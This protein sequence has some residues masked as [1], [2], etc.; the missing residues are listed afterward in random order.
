[1]RGLILTSSIVL[2]LS[3][4]SSFAGA[5][6]RVIQV[7][8]AAE[9]VPPG[10]ETYR[11]YIYDM[12][13]YVDRKDK[14]EIV[15]LLKKQ[16]DIVEDSGLSPK[17]MQFFHTVPIIAS[18]MGCTD[19]GPPIACYSSIRQE[20][21]ARDHTFTVWD[22]KTMSWSNPNFV[23]LAADAGT[24]VIRFR[25]I[26]LKHAEDPVMLH[27]LLHAYHHKLMGSGFDNLGIKAMY[28]KAVSTNAFP[29]D[30]YVMT[31]AHEFF[32]VTASVF[33][34]GKGALSEPKTRAALK[35]KMPK[36]YKFLVE[37]FGF[38]PEPSATPVAETA[39]PVE[40]AATAPANGT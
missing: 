20:T 23:D 10:F 33:L 37:L 30:E 36:Y 34:A 18:E 22:P 38:D 1:M 11:G 3:F 4:A 25:P 17:V 15:G 32:A 16:L 31:N 35:E 12:S 2:M 27:E 29:K 8:P 24:G 6:P 40:A 26:M 28:A 7:D 19:F 39:K 21:S 9:A 5:G 14:E 13:E